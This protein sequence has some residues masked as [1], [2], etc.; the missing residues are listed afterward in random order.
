MLA[1]LLFL[2]RHE[3]YML[4]DGRA[5]DKGAEARALPSCCYAVQASCTFARSGSSGLA[6]CGSLKAIVVCKKC[7]VARRPG[8]W[9]ARVIG[10]GKR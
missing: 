7:C 6:Q 3:A 9:C 8:A 2:C 5:E 10:K 1:T 4:S